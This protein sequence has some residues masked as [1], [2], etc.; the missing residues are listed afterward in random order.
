MK[1]KIE[2]YL[3]DITDLEVDAIV[4]AADNH[5][6]MGG[7]VAFAIKRKGGKIIEDE[8]VEQGPISIGDAIITTAGKLKATYVIHAAAMGLDFKTD[9]NKIKNATKNSLKRAEELKIKS[10]AFP[11]IGTGIGHFPAKRAAE[12]MIDVVKEHIAKQ[13]NLDKIIFALF[14]MNTYNAFKEALDK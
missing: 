9:E 5:L 10:I 6:R 8:A 13:T 11:A 4:N 14:N 2:L 7:G 1:T 12:I 3:G